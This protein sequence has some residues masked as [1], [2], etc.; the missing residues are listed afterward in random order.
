MLAGVLVLA[1]LLFP[2][3]FPPTCCKTPIVTRAHL[4]WPTIFRPP[5]ARLWL[6]ENNSC[7]V[8]PAQ[9]WKKINNPSASLTF[10][11]WVR[12]YNYQKMPNSCLRQQKVSHW[13]WLFGEM[14]AAQSCRCYC[15]IKRSLSKCLRRFRRLEA[16]DIHADATTISFYYCYYYGGGE[17]RLTITKHKHFVLF[18]SFFY[19]PCFN[20]SQNEITSGRGSKFDTKLIPLAFCRSVNNT[21]ILKTTVSKTH[22]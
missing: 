18:V 13:H 17:I 11:S 5:W 10:R 20:F 6:E 8:L 12:I 19:L 9:R 22:L 1:Q 3:D 2:P 21:A 14:A 4:Q 7:K 15:S 16:W